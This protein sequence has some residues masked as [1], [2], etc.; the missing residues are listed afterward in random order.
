VD[1]PDRDRVQEV[2]LLAPAP[3]GHDQAG[4]LELPQVLHHPEAGHGEAPLERGQR[5]AVLAEELV[6]QAPP[7]GVGQRSEHRVHDREHT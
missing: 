5:L 7:R 6:E 4:L 3:P 1:E 2:Q